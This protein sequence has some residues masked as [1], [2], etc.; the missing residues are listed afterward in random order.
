MSTASDR[1]R[2]NNLMKSDPH[3]HWCRKPLKYSFKSGGML[4]DDFPTLDHLNDRILVKK[5]PIYYNKEVTV[6]SCPPCNYTRA[7]IRVL[8]YWLIA[9]WKSGAF[10]YPFRWVGY[11]LKF[12]RGQKRT[13]KR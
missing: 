2:R 13:N 3:C 5:R 10:P 9:A 6:L 12:V 7:S 11:T 8:Q 1:K 4:P